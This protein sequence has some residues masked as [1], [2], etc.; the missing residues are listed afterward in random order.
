MLLLLAKK[1][2]RHSLEVIRKSKLVRQL[3]GNQLVKV[4]KVCT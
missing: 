2:E 3:Q 4:K 1:G